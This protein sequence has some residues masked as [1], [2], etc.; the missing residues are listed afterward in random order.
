MYSVNLVVYYGPIYSYLLSNFIARMFINFIC[1]KNNC[2]QITHLLILHFLNNNWTIN[3]IYI[4][5]YSEY[6]LK[7][8]V[9]WTEVFKLKIHKEYLK[10]R[11]FTQIPQPMHKVS[12]ISAILEL[13]S[14]TIHC[15][16][17]FWSCMIKKQSAK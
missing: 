11:T 9:G 15:F 1:Y 5:S 2:S 6:A 17:K 4:S 8:S 14:T 7:V 13:L 3:N 10:E 16:P 12:D